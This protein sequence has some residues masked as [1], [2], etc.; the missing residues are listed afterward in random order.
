MFARATAF[1]HN[2]TG[3]FTP[4][5]SYSERLFESA[6]SW[7]AKFKRVDGSTS[8]DGPPSSWTFRWNSSYLAVF[9]QR[10]IYQR[11]STRYLPAL[12]TKWMKESHLLLTYLLWHAMCA[13]RGSAQTDCLSRSSGGKKQLLR[14]L[15]QVGLE[16]RVEFW[17][18]PN[19][20]FFRLAWNAELCFGA[21][22]IPFS[23]LRS[24]QE[25]DLQKAVLTP[26][27]PVAKNSFWDSFFKGV[28]T[29]F[30]RSFSCLDLKLEN[31][32]R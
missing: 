20:N 26:F 23:S 30:W 7:L 15:F 16:C 25:N 2:I 24:K 17:C 27:T 14:Q 12:I 3:W 4:Q 18:L 1:N 31:E 29:A 22:R 10:G 6:T 13:L 11:W 5:L 32:I 28:K 21:Y 9:Y 19:S 8:V